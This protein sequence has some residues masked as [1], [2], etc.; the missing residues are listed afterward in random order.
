MRILVTGSES[1][2]E[3]HPIRQAFLS[4]TLSAHG[5]VVEV[6]HEPRGSV[7]AIASRIARADWAFGLVD[8]PLEPPLPLDD[9]DTVW[10]FLQAGTDSRRAEA[11]IARCREAD[12]LITKWLS[13]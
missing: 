6:I 9:I 8:V 1:F 12:I 2:A 7:N 4:K 3:E 10:A 5:E 11:L 13:R